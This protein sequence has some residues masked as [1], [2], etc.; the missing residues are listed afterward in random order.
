VEE[1]GDLLVDRVGVEQELALVPQQVVLLQVL[2]GQALLVQRD[3]AAL[4][5][6][7]HPEVQQLQALLLLPGHRS[8]ASS[9]S[10]VV[11]SL[12]VCGRWVSGR[13]VAINGGSMLAVWR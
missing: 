13:G 9:C 10:R 12:A 8:L 4:P 3:A 1:H 2:V 6:R 7:A 11:R 5:E